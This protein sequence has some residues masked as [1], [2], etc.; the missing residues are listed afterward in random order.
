[1]IKKTED[2]VLI[3]VKSFILH[4]YMLPKND[5]CISFIL[6]LT[7]ISTRVFNE[8]GKCFIQ[9]KWIQKDYLFIVFYYFQKARIAYW[10]RV[11]GFLTCRHELSPRT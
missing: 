3:L 5:V 10:C 6:R 8:T 4:F 11:Y 7:K 9:L 2:N 1:M